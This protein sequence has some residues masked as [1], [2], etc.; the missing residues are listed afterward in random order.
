MG[1]T[2]VAVL[3]SARC[4]VCASMMH[5]HVHDGEAGNTCLKSAPTQLNCRCQQQRAVDSHVR[6]WNL[7]LVFLTN[8]SWPFGLTAVQPCPAMVRE[9]EFYDLLGAQ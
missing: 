9:T 6:V 3:E 7:L 1:K 2:R 8:R 4:G 5:R